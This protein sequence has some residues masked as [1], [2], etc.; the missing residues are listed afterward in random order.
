M[1][2]QSVRRE[3][4][5]V[6]CFASIGDGWADLSRGDGWSGTGARQLARLG[7]AA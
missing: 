4:C 1:V 2:R 5:A 6:K 7:R 3:A